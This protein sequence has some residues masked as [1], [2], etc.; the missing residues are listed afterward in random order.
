MLCVECASMATMCA[1]CVH[2][3][4]VGIDLCG[5]VQIWLL[6]ALYVHVATNI[7]YVWYVQVWLLCV[8]HLCSMH[9]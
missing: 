6:C 3:F 5:Y 7:C 9:L 8:F 4:Y 1:L 2:C